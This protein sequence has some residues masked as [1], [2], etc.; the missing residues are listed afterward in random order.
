[1]NR[2]EFREA[3]NAFSGLAKDNFKIPPEL[4]VEHDVKKGL[5]NSNGTGVLVGLTEIGDVVGYELQDGKKVAVPGQLKYR[6]IDVEDI[7]NGFLTEDRLG[8]EEVCFLLLF[9]Q[10]PD[11]AA[12]VEFKRMLGSCRSLPEG[13]TRDMI[14]KAPSMNIMNKLA[15]SVLAMYSY[16]E[17]PEDL[18][19]E[20]VLR[21]SIELMARFPAMAA[22]GYQATSYY[23]GG[24]SLFLHKPDPALSTAENFLMMLRPDGQFTPTEAATLDLS[25]VLHAD[26]GGGNNSAY[27]V[28]VVSSTGT[29]TYSAIA[30]AIG[31][32][33]GPKHGG[34]NIKVI[35]MMEDIKEHLTNWNDDEEITRYLQKISAK[36]AFD[37]SG[38]IYGVGHAIYTLSD[39]RAVLLKR[40]AHKLAE[41]KGAMDEFNLFAK[42]EKLAP[43]EV[44]RAK[45]SEKP[46]CI[47]VDFYSGFI[48]RLLNIPIEVSTPL[49]A[50]SRIS[51]WCAHRIEELLTVNQII[52]PAFKCVQT[53]RA[54]IPMG[55]RSP[56]TLPGLTGEC[57]RSET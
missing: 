56:L 25:L 12:L 8:F 6:G 21:Q 16:D 42:I 39:P 32:L 24:R 4:F 30:A 31:S 52:R 23:H 10:M 27:T 20:N 5:R 35:E 40:M 49:F 50:I 2:K 22:Y 44:Q 26:H 48:Y 9:G 46:F 53:P 34:A 51:G 14:L 19:V 7:V 54:Y 57:L 17:N 33:K 36:E 11:A 28:R 13:F 3:I 55:A 1:M 18:S 38:L 29:D 43:L 37:K 45:Q 47:N 41:E 15:R